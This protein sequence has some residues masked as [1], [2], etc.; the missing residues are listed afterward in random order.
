MLGFVVTAA[1]SSTDHGIRFVGSATKV[2]LPNSNDFGYTHHRIVS[3]SKDLPEGRYE[4]SANGQ[5]IALRH[6]NNQW[7]PAQ[8]F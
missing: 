6:Q 7:L 2:G 3:V 4:L 1:D 8:A 5:V